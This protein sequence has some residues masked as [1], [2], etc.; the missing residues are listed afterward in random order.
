MEKAEV[1]ITKEKS[2]FE[3]AGMKILRYICDANSSHSDTSKVIQILDWPE[4]TDVI[5]ACIFISF[6]VYEQ[7]WIQ[8][9]VNVPISISR[10]MK[11]NTS[12]V[13]GQKYL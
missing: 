2:Q 9:I 11:E 7:I 1:T 12:F 6:Y 13:W 8:G 10:L 3:Q 5:S 4:C